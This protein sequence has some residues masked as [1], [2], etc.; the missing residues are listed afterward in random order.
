MPGVR[1]IKAL[2]IH[3]QYL[4]NQSLLNPMTSE[5]ICLECTILHEQGLEHPSYT[6]T[7]FDID[8][9]SAFIIKSKSNVIMC[10]LEDST[11]FDIS[12][13]QATMPPPFSQAPEVDEDASQA[14]MPPP[15]SQATAFDDDASQ[16]TIP[17]PFSQS[18][19]PQ[20][21][22]ETTSPTNYEADQFGQTDNRADSF[23]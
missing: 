11:D 1:E 2:I 19:P 14:T 16:G 23:I 3:C 18:I 20:Q 12:A 7:L 21:S 9:I 13:S 22:Q 4:I 5:N 17:P 15:F 10:Q 8:C 6:S